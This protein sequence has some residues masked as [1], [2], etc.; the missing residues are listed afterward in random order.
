MSKMML[1]RCVFL[2]LAI[3]IFLVACNASPSS[4]PLVQT[5]EFVTQPVQTLKPTV[6]A[7]Q[8]PSI[9]STPALT[10]TGTPVVTL[11]AI[12]GNSDNYQLTISAPE[13]LIRILREHTSQNGST[14]EEIRELQSLTLSDVINHEWR[15]SYSSDA[16][17]Q[18]LFELL[19]ISY[20][21]GRLP[22]EILVDV[23]GD[24]VVDYLNRES[25]TLQNDI[26]FEM[27]PIYSL[28][29]AYKVEID[30]DNLPEW[31]INVESPS[32][33]GNGSIWLTV[34]Q[35]ENGL[36]T[37]MVNQLPVFFGYSSVEYPDYQLHDIT[38]DGIMDAVIEE[39]MCGFGDCVGVYR[40]VAGSPDGFR[41]I[42]TSAKSGDNMGGAS[43]YWSE[44]NWSL[45]P[46]NQLPMLEITSF[47]NLGAFECTRSSKQRFQWVGNQER[48]KEY[49]AAYPD[50]ALCNI[51]YAMDR[52]AGLDNKARIR[53]L[54][55][56]YTHQD[57][58]SAEYKVF[59]LYR[60]A[61][62]HALE[63][64]DW[65]ARK[66]LELL[67]EAAG[68]G[69]TPIADYLFEEI[70]PLLAEKNVRPYKLCM[71]AEAILEINEQTPF[72]WADG[73]EKYPYKGFPE[74][75]S[76]SLCDT[77]DI[78]EEILK[79]IKPLLNESIE[80]VLREA[81][82]PVTL[83]LSLTQQDLPSTWL[84][85]IKDRDFEFSRLSDSKEDKLN[86]FSYSTDTGWSKL[87]TLPIAQYDEILFH[88]TD[89]TGDGIPDPAIVTRYKENSWCNGDEF[90]EVLL[91]ATLVF[92]H[93][94]FF[95][96]NGD[97]RFCIPVDQPFDFEYLLADRNKDGASDWVAGNMER[98]FYDLNLLKSVKT[99]SSIIH[100]I[101]F[102]DHFMELENLIHKPTILE[103]LTKQVIVSS[104]RASLRDEI[105]FYRDRWGIDDEAGRNI[106][107]QLNYLLAL[108]Y[109][110]DENEAQAKVI[111][112]EIWQKQPNTLWA[113]LAASRLEYKP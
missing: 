38:G 91:I 94:L 42:K 56:A 40:I 32:Y 76:A 60:L 10:P 63:G 9:A 21:E 82:I 59:V 83:A 58:L 31:L 54:N 93:T 96:M 77:L 61:L 2:I 25:I 81:G 7:T 18:K 26:F 89:I 98:D 103:R 50:T 79:T 88:S 85:I 23:I 100:Y 15:R 28:G 20:E 4:T 75:Y 55:Q 97:E 45:S 74:G 6:T 14:S 110:L 16:Y 8:S 30:R 52:R 12:Q 90:Y 111:L 84:V 112:Y 66:Y 34:S 70:Q 27:L 48:V 87:M 105:I 19:P 3:S 24:A 72:N 35:N 47:W 106:R 109:E 33:F 13:N 49:P 95:T 113:N 5:D 107:A 62:L 36:Y 1:K 69:T 68:S 51:A 65:A 86:I 11:P 71:A 57:G 53:L 108:T 46:D 44:I 92:D 22:D 64:D 39:S 17:S 101:D 78:Q 43:N 37:R 104:D 99:N 102:G 67:S 29:K 80:V 41:K 73:F